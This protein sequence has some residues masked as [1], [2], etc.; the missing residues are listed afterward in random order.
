MIDIRT[1]T[2]ADS[3]PIAGLMNALGYPDAA[4]YIERR[5]VQ[6]TAHPDEELLV[7]TR[8]GEVVGVIS[9]HFIPQLALAGDYC[10]ISYFCVSENAR[11]EGVGAALE[12]RTVE[13]ARERGCDSIEVHSNSRREDAHRFYYRQGYVESPKYLIKKPG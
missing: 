9:I 5:I 7:A 6:L 13:L 10:R 12:A 1:A 3:R 11:S 2:L 8:N 4:S